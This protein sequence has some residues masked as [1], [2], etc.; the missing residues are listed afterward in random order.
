MTFRALHVGLCAV[1]LCPGLL[2]GMPATHGLQLARPTETDPLAH[3]LLQATDFS[4]LFSVE[5]VS[6]EL[7]TDFEGILALQGLEF[8]ANIRTAPLR[9]FRSSERSALLQA[10]DLRTEAGTLSGE[11]AAVR[12]GDGALATE[13]GVLRAEDGALAT[14]TT[15]ARTGLYG[16]SNDQAVRR[17][18]TGILEN[19]KTA[20][21][22]DSG[23]LETELRALDKASTETTVTPKKN[24][25]RSSSASVLASGES[26]LTDSE[27]STKTAEE[28][29]AEE[30]ARKERARQRQADQA[31]RLEANTR[32][33]TADM[34]AN[35]ALAGLVVVTIIS[36]AVYDLRGKITAALSGKSTYQPY[37]TSP[38]PSDQSSVRR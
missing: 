4:D 18:E 16:A 2:L 15:T 30:E 10:L 23:F 3:H 11:S 7:E 27:E 14:E 22:T 1:G 9:S 20:V 29:R 25:A 24:P 21:R 32:N 34:I 37:H 17:I 13:T 5:A 28:I 26:L 35:G 12:T 38:N 6:E 8:Y 33:R 19:R 36:A 31:A